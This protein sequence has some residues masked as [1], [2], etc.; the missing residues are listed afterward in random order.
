VPDHDLTAYQINLRPVQPGDL[1]AAQAGVDGQ[2]EQCAQPAVPAALEE[3]TDL[4]GL[5]GCDIV[6]SYC[7]LS[8]ISAGFAEMI[9]SLT[10]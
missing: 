3:D 9:S 5:P 4:L 2:L 6:I 7:W 8:T 1:T 10:A